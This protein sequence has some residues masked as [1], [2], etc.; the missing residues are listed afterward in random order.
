MTKEEEQ[1][2]QWLK[3]KEQ[4]IQWPKEEEQ[5]IQWSKE[6]YLHDTTQTNEDLERRTQQKPGMNYKKVLHLQ[7]QEDQLKFARKS[8]LLA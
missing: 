7:L 4:T 6:T 5:T 3:E 8:M 2:I 1:T